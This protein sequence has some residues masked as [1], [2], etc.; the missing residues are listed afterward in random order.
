M[1]PILPTLEEATELVPREGGPVWRYA[2]DLRSAAGGGAPYALMLQV[3]HP[4]VGAGVS[5]H[6]NFR[7]DPWSRLLR[8]LDFLTC[9]IFGGPE[10]A[11]E[12]C[13]RVRE[14][15][16]QIKG[17][18]PNGES[19][20]ALEPEPYAWVHATLA[21][22]I[23]RGNE[24]FIQPIPERDLEPFWAEW[25]RM[26]RLLGVRER[27]LPERWS[28]FGDY[29]DWMVAERLE[30]TQ[31]VDD[32]LEA[33]EEPPPPPVRGIPEPVWKAARLP[34]RRGARIGLVGMMPSTF[35]R[36]LGLRWK[37]GNDLEFRAMARAMR[38]SGPL[39]PR[40]VKEFG[41]HYLR[42]RREAIARGE[43][44]SGVGTK[45]APKPTPVA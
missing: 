29:F 34:A 12:T 4:V 22:A 32:V 7:A 31:S 28:E 24:H 45:F 2:N 17:T 38:M 30:R 8:T 5:D 20:H 15:H 13:T 33:L 3:A 23:I 6:S 25:R 18:L 14:M 1:A 44:A 35:R 39:L 26:G 11:H 41:P 40:A 42:W 21:D 16:K 43:V 10:L 37:R 27:D 9:T 36:K 19:Y